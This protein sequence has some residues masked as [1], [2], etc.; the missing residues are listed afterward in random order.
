MGENVRDNFFECAQN[1]ILE[2]LAHIKLKLPLQD[3]IVNIC[4]IIQLKDMS[5]TTKDKVCNRVVNNRPKK[6]MLIVLPDAIPNRH[7]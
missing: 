3:N 6:S 4:E 5:N 2:F 1:Y 7:V